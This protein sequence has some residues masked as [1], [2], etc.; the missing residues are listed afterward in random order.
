MTLSA[1]QKNSLVLGLGLSQLIGWGSMYY[2]FGVLMKPMQQELGLSANVMV[3]A[4]SLALLISGA[5]SIFTGRIIDRLGG[6]L[7]MSA[8]SVLCAVMLALSAFVHDVSGLYLVWAGIGV[9]MSAT[10]YQSAFAVLIQAFGDGYRRAITSLTLIAGFAS[11]LAWPL[12]QATL[13][14]FGWRHTWLL[15]A[16]ANLLLCLP[17]H[18]RLP[19]FRKEVARH[20]AITRVET[21]GSTLAAEAIPSGVHV[22]AAEEATVIESAAPAPPAA[23]VTAV[24]A[25]NAVTASVPANESATTS[26][27]SL[28]IATPGLTLAR[29]VRDPAFQLVTLAITLSSLVSSAILLHLLAFLQSRG[30]AAHQAALIGALLGPMQVL[31][32]ILEIAFGRHATSK[33]VGTLAMWLA[34]LGIALLV[35]P[36]DGLILYAGFALIYGLGN[37]VMTIVRGTLP[38]ELYGQT[39]YGMVSGAMS[40]PVMFANAAGPF[41]ATLLYTVAG[42]YEAVIPLLGAVSTLAVC[43]FMIGLARV[44]NSPDKDGLINRD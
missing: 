41:M 25:V 24:S 20:R 5:L 19:R 21:P 28:C 3:G 30:I 39:S 26:T 13:S 23:A 43:L 35:F 29:L 4:Y 32:R 33:Q 42:G 27:S 9:A 37:G 16:L 8:G 11:T 44:G 10:L 12:T 31:G 7:L 18:L 17:V 2:A 40:A 15:L 38:V 22:P 14:A 34:P 6:R 1:R 36:G